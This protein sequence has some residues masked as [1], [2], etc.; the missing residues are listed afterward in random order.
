MADDNGRQ[1]L[2][3]L[4]HMLRT[5]LVAA[6]WRLKSALQRNP[7]ERNDVI[8]AHGAVARVM[9]TLMNLRLTADLT[10]GAALRLSASLITMKDL[11]ERLASMVSDIQLLY[12]EVRFHLVPVDLDA[13]ISLDEELFDVAFTNV[14]DNAGK[15]SFT[16]TEVIIGVRLNKR[17][18]IEICV[19]NEGIRMAAE[20]LDKARQRGWR[21]EQA[22]AISQSGSG[23]GLWITD[24]IAN[25]HRGELMLLP[26]TRDNTTEVRLVFPQANK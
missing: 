11:G 25:A 26:T 5:P 23:I 3:D 9:R 13:T 18:H 20:T 8:A 1:F 6:Q 22:M 24:R 10:S 12:P 7:P 14:L 16:G 17:G 4:V 2:L 15:Y 19:S 21:D